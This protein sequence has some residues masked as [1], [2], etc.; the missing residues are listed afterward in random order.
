MR[1]KAPLNDLEHCED[2]QKKKK[3]DLCSNSIAQWFNQQNPRIHSY[4]QRRSNHSDLLIIQFYQ[5]KA[6]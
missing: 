2:S 6:S 5:T 1:P 3:K 4:I